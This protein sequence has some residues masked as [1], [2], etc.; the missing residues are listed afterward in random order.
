MTIESSNYFNGGIASPSPEGEGILLTKS[1]LEMRNKVL[2][3]E[4]SFFSIL[5]QIDRKFSEFKKK[6]SRIDPSSLDTESLK[7]LLETCETLNQS[8]GYANGIVFGFID[9]A[10]VHNMTPS[11]II[12]EIMP[13]FGLSKAQALAHIRNFCELRNIDFKEE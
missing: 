11:E 8:Y 2:S 1:I 9:C 3:D 13:Q 12:E 5:T 10:L 6:T 4:T 7:E